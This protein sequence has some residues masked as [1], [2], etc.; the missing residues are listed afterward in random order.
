MA[1]APVN[2]LS[3]VERITDK[4]SRFMLEAYVFVMMALEHTVSRLAVRRH[5]TAKE[6][7]SGAKE[8]AVE[9]YGPTAKMVLNHWGIRTTA[10]IGQI[11]FNLVDAEVL[12]KT[13]TDKK[14]DF[15]NVFDFDDVF[16]RQYEW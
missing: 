1:D 3:K 14:E 8:L 4:D 10:D 7:L 13:E 12:A 16:V 11:V 6:L 5:I 9:K 2:D 15:Q